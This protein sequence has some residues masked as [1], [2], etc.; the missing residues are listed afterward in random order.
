MD[1]DLRDIFLQLLRLGIGLGDNA[2]IQRLSVK[3]WQELVGMANE[4]GLLGVMLDGME[5]LPRD[6][7]PEK[8]A[9][10]QSI[11]QVIHS[12]QK[13]S[14]QE[15]AAKEMA[16]LLHQ[17]GIRTYVLKG[18]VVAECYPK[19][20]HRRSVD[21]DCFLLS[22]EGS[23]D[24]WE[25]ANCLMERQGFKVRRDYYKNS[26][27]V[28]PGLSVENHRY[29]TPFRGN[30]R[31]HRLE[32]LLQDEM[33]RMKGATIDS[34]FEGTYLYRPPVM[35]SALF[36]IEHAYSHF[37][38]EGLTWR[39]VLDWMMFSRKHQDEIDWK[40]LNA[41]V[42]EFGLN[43]FYGS[44]YR[45]G[46]YL[47]GEITFDVLELSDKLMLN[48][49]WA[50]LDVHETVRG[51]RGKLALAGN[52]WRARWKYRHFTD[53]TWLRALWIQ[54]KGVMFENNPSI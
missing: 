36:L 9:I 28:L 33:L 12:E 42:A 13:Y 5:K 7:R 30:K 17:H 49:I 21:M 51:L 52:T 22:E 26:T 4:Q 46:R 32:R 23:T 50:P 29:F 34:N 1:T 48:D 27:I 38:H 40:A 11:G 44:Y 47:L 8:K 37:L 18:A 43:R 10:I 39:I 53:M 31:L 25:N 20:E 19:P 14:V 24:V 35:V 16:L 41:G 3:D 45:L 2:E 54:A 15:N 6:L